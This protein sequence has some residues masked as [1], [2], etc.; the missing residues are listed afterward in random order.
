ML[1]DAGRIVST[2]EP[3]ATRGPL[4]AIVRSATACAWAVRAD[5]PADVAGE[6]DRLARDEPPASDLRDAPAFADRYV[7]LLKD[8]SHRANCPRPRPGNPTD[9]PSCSPMQFPARRDRRCDDERLLDRHFRGWVPG[10]IA[11][12]RAPVM[13]I[14][15]DDV[16][17]SICF[18][19]RPSEVAAEA[20]LETAEAYRGRGYALASRRRGRW[21]SAPRGGIPSTAPRGRTTP[22]S[23]WP[24]SWGSRLTRVVGA[25]GLDRRARSPG[26]AQC[27]SAR[28]T[29][30]SSVCCETLVPH[31]VDAPQSPPDRR[32][33]VDPDLR[34]R[35]TAPRRERV[36]GVS[37]ASWGWLVKREAEEAALQRRLHAEAANGSGQ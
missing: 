13:A 8:R 12:G 7:S 3:E 6:L 36:A 28:C 15:E 37:I 5:L 16:P 18:C 9:R 22:R 34:Q 11:A 29:R 35:L 14:V 1:D 4:F 23:P 24:T 30:R 33:R 32:W 26:I 10:E 2:R 25:V 21:R 27:P 31:S 19:A 17:V 20:G